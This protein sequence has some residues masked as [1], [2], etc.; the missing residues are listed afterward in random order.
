MVVG[1]IAFKKLYFCNVFYDYYMSFYIQWYN[2][3]SLF[4]SYTSGILINNLNNLWHFRGTVD[5][6]CPY[7]ILVSVAFQTGYRYVIYSF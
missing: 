1:V 3:L 7:T 6:V 5:T 2:K 4:F